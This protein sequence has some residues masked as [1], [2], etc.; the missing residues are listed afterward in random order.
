MDPSLE[1]ERIINGKL[2]FSVNAHR[3]KH[4]SYINDL[5]QNITLACSEL[6]AIQKPGGVGIS[7]SLIGK[8]SRQAIKRAAE[9]HQ[10]LNAALTTLEA[11]F[12]ANRAERLAQLQKQ[13][14]Q[15]VLQKKKEEESMEI[16]VVDGGLNI[17]DP[18]LS[19]QNVH[20]PAGLGPSKV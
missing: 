16:D 11:N 18:V 9:L 19:F 10:H 13:Y 1:E 14:Q 3:Y 4:P 15:Q 2:T 6:C 7:V 17:N 8:A 5:Q 20:V 12:N